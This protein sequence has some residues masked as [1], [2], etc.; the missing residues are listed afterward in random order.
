MQGGEGE[1][2]GGGGNA[3]G[4][5]HWKGGGGHG[6]GGALCNVGFG[7]ILLLRTCAQSALRDPLVA[8]RRRVE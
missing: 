4:G 5:G 1:C 7:G 3:R 6:R 8:D 2:K